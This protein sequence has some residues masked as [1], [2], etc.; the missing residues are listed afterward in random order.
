MRRVLI[1]SP[2]RGGIP[3]AYFNLLFHL[4]VT[5]QTEFKFS[6]AFVGRCGVQWARDECAAR[7]KTLGYTG[8]D[9][10]VFIDLDLEPSPDQVLRLCSHDEDV[11]IGAYANRGTLKTHFHVV[12][13]PNSEARPDGLMQIQKCAVGF[14][15]ITA[16]AFEKL[17]KEI[18]ERAYWKF[19]AGETT[20]VQM[21]EFFP[22]GIVGPNSHEGKLR[23]IREVIAQRERLGHSG[24]NVD[25]AQVY[26]IKEILNDTD[27]STNQISGEDYYFCKLCNDAEIPIYWDTEIVVP[28]MGEVLTPVPTKDLLETLNEPWRAD[29]VRA[30]T[31]Q[32]PQEET[33]IPT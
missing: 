24:P 29:E 8:R 28:H 20:G 12:G 23:R 1:A 7:L 2:V 11:V 18:P 9:K 32:K 15:A 13:I 26:D 17:R 22:M 5:K 30:L 25:Y 3:P 16:D 33:L 14:A 10:L 6:F 31:E 19:D 4:L 21:H 27:Y